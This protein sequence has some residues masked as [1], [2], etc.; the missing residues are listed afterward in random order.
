MEGLILKTNTIINEMIE[1][2]YKLPPIPNPMRPSTFLKRAQATF[3]PINYDFGQKTITL[4]YDDKVPK[5]VQTCKTIVENTLR[6]Y[7][8]D[9]SYN[10]SHV[11]MYPDGNA[12]VDPHEDNEDVIDQTVPIA[13]I[14]FGETRKFAF[15][16]HQTSEERN[17]QLEKSKAKVNPAPKPVKI[18]STNLHNGD[19]LLMVNMQ[20]IGILHGIVK[21]SKVKKPRLNLTYRRF[22]NP[23]A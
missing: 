5:V 3:S 8:F 19:V 22:L 1:F 10:G 9:K 16:R 13:S 12:G 18:V 4:P 23:N 20:K 11:S 21:D 17:K 6:E 15:Y 14:S 7:N 2:M